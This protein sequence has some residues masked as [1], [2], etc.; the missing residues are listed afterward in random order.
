MKY[1]A[2]SGVQ[3]RLAGIL[4]SAAVVS[5]AAITLASAPAQ[6]SPDVHYSFRT[7]NNAD[8]PTF[9]Q[10]LGINDGGKIAGYFGSGAKNHPNKGYT[11]LKP[12]RQTDFRNQ[13]FPRS[14]QTQVTG[15]NNGDIQVG[16]YSTMNKANLSDNNFGYYS[17]NG[18][19]FHKVN[20]PAR[21]P[22][23]P[24]V[25]QLL[26]VND[27]GLAAGFYVDAKGNSHGYL[28]NIKTKRYST[29]NPRVAGETSVTAT[30]INDA[31]SVAGFFT[32]SKGAVHGFLLR[33]SAPHLF[34]LVFP[35]SDSTTPLGVNKFGEVVGSYTIGSKTFGFTWTRKS[36]FRTINDPA[37]AGNT[38]VNGINSAG[39]LVGFYV[40]RNGNTNGFLAK[41]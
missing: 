31:D 6:A 13:N 23:S 30:G 33:K 37:G 11:L 24:P 19:H 41:P 29:V 10:L 2:T 20:Y 5:A 1:L 7:I 28:Y 25:D 27:A 12:Y 4:A 8:D 21:N 35:G 17:V 26:G 3:R 40:G 34:V 16:F 36:G 15:L 22:A 39:D 9:N 14:K 32:T 18:K 38:I